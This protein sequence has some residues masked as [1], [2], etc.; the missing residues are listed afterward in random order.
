MTMERRKENKENL[1]S[2]DEGEEQPVKKAKVGH[3]GLIKPVFRPPKVTKKIEPFKESDIS[4]VNK[5][6]SVPKF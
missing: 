3:K 2:E 1:V 4:S 6:V 5:L